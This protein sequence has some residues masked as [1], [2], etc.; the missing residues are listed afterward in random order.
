MNK[1]AFR[2][3]ERSVI[4]KIP[5]LYRLYFQYLIKKKGLIKV[6]KINLN[7]AETV[8]IEK[9]LKK[10]LIVGLVPD[11]LGPRE[12]YAYPRAYYPKYERF[13][14]NNNIDY[15]YYDIHQSNWI[16]LGKEFDLIVWHTASDPAIQYI[17]KNKFMCLKS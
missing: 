10:P 6:E 7:E 11:G 16:N 4:F 14:K 2:D 1:I 3:M 5:F 17:A 15:K 9:P 8:I 12:G 13:L